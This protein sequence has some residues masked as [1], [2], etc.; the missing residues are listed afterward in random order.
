MTLN[1]YPHLQNIGITGMQQLY[2]VLGVNPGLHSCWQ[3]LYQDYIPSLPWQVVFLFC[4]L[5]FFNLVVCYLIFL[6]NSFG[7][8]RNRF[9]VVCSWE[10]SSSTLPHSES[11]VSCYTESCLIRRVSICLLLVL[12]PLWLS[13]SESLYLCLHLQG[14]SYFFLQQH[15]YWGNSFV[16]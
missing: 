10:R 16:L 1:F 11:A 13:L 15:Q 4:F 2:V 5:F 3:I 8:T 6:K 12:L 7:Y 14:I 9:S